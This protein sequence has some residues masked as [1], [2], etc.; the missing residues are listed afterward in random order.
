MVAV[1]KV[2]VPH[3]RTRRSAA[4]TREHILAVAAE[5]FYWE[6]I[7]ATGV[8]TVAARADVAPTTLYRLFASK[9]DLVAAYVDRCSTAY[10]ELLSA[11]SAP[12]VGT[13]RRRILAVFD[14]FTNEVL[15]ASCRGCPFLMVLGEFPDPSSAPH[16][17]AVAH[18]TWL[19]A[20]FRDLVRALGKEVQLRQPAK[21]ADNL[22][23]VAEGMYGSV[24]ALGAS[25]P[26]RQ[27]RACAEVLL[28]AAVVR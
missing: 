28:D 10:R 14:A 26:A 18:K 22:A 24:Q 17:G 8:D 23:L 25:G 21:L 3:V 15:A 5:L 4:D 27:G 9:E 19:R 12:P 2:A 20:L 11:A 16:V 1:A 6:G 13:A 7:R